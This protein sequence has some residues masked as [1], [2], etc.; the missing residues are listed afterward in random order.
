MVDYEHLEEDREEIELNGFCCCKQT[1]SSQLPVAN[2][3]D[4]CKVLLWLGR[5]RILEIF[6][7]TNFTLISA[8]L[9]FHMAG[10]SGFVERALRGSN[11]DEGGF[12]RKSTSLVMLNK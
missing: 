10:T 2:T 4:C 11:R 12:A 6:C 1:S 8:I 9:K 3:S 7:D 5:H